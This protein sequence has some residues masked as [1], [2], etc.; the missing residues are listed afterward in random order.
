MAGITRVH[1]LLHEF[2][3][4]LLAIRRCGTRQPVRTH[5]RNGRRVDGDIVGLV[6]VIDSPRSE[7]IHQ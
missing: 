4:D 1:T 7:H 3:L 2:H 6:G 5:H